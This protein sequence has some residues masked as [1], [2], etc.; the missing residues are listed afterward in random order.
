M[1]IESQNTKEIRIKSIGHAPFRL[2]HTG[3]LII[4]PKDFIVHDD[5][6]FNPDLKQTSAFK[7][8]IINS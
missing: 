8:L 4:S 1:A 7:C 5:D 3:N 2:S 6:Y